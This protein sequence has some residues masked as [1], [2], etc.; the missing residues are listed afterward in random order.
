MDIN[1][2]ATSIVNGMSELI[3]QA[4]RALAVERSFPGPDADRMDEKIKGCERRIAVLRKM[5]NEF[6]DEMAV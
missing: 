2:T 5:R 6:E 3:A 4:S 1:A